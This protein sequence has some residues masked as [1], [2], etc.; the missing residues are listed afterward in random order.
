MFHEEDLRR[1]ALQEQRLVFEQ[2]GQDEAWALGLW[3]RQ[4]GLER[5]GALVVDV[6]LHRQQ[7]LRLAVGPATPDHD[8]WVRRKRATALHFA[9]S[10]YAIGISLAQ[11]GTTL[12]IK[13]GLPHRD[14]A[15]HGG[16]VPLVVKGAGCIGALTVSGLPQRED[17]TLAMAALA[18][19]QGRDISDIVLV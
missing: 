5:G 19:V 8:D 11:Q 14:Y 16:A 13:S 3:L 2:F 17:H 6:S 15:T 18:H 10:S 12:E 4:A 7:M 1:I 9:R